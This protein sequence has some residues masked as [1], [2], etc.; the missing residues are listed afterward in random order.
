MTTKTLRPSSCNLFSKCVAAA[1]GKK[2]QFEVR[3]EGG[4]A[5]VG[6]ALHDAAKALVLRESIPYAE[7][8]RKWALN[9]SQRREM[10]RMIGC[11]RKY[12]D[13]QLHAGGWSPTLVAEQRLEGTYTT[14][15]CTYNLGGTM[16]VG[17]MSRD[18]RIWGTIDWKSTRLET[19]DY[20]AQQ[21]VYL[22]LAKEWWKTTESPKRPEHYQYH[23][24]YVR[25]WTEEVSEAYTPEELDAMREAAKREKRT[26]RYP[27]PE[28]FATADDAEQ[29]RAEGRPVVVRLVCPPRDVTIRDDAFGEVTMPAAEMDD[30]VILKGDGWPT[31]HLANVVDDELMGVNYI[32]RGQEFLGQT[33]RHVLLR[34]ALG[35]R[36]PRYC[37]LPL[38][39][40]MAGRKLSKRDGAVEVHAFR[41]AGYL[42]EVLVNFIALLGWKPSGQRE[43]FTLA[44]M[45]EL[46]S[47]DRIGRANAKF[48]RDKLVA[49]NTDA[50][51]AADADRL[52]AAFKDYLSLNDTAIPGDDD[53]L[54]RYLV[55]INKGFRTFADIPAKCGVLFVADDAFEYDAKAVEKVLRKNDGAGF[56]VL[57]ELRGKLAAC[58]WTPEAVEAM[59]DG[60]CKSS[61]LGM[62]KVAQPV[63]VAVTGSTISPPIHDTLAIL[64]REKTLARIDRCLASR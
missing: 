23:I 32:C 44:E 54:L 38:I 2:D 57:G 30:F 55:R 29:A 46:F 24:V 43:K 19:A 21:M 14:E 56:N 60:Y 8:Q 37:H 22:W 7:I 9:K 53:E 52:L 50:A 15:A 3:W 58:P 49:F 35:F 51:A 17:G 42:P 13:E 20:A 59:I 36:E 63:R 61:G 33:W 47:A 45:I 18:G 1:H 62:G 4:A 28:S 5:V 41:S 40:D 25:D 11:V 39:L 16:D 10:G 26:F 64:G 12:C 27:H 34:Q 48:D 31:Y 6:S